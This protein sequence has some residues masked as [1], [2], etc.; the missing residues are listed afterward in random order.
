MAGLARRV[1][2]GCVMARLGTLGRGVVWL[3][4][5]GDVGLGEVVRGLVRQGKVSLG[6]HGTETIFRKGNNYEI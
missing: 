2:V 6:R 5:C 1:S 3:G 4:R